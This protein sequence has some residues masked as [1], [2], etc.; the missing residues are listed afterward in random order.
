MEMCSSLPGGIPHPELTLKQSIGEVD[1]EEAEERIWFFF[2]ARDYQSSH[3]SLLS[4]GSNEK[5]DV[6]QQAH[7]L[8]LKLWW[9][10]L[11]RATFSPWGLHCVV[12]EGQAGTLSSPYFLVQTGLYVQ[13]L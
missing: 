10:S 3:Y 12:R 11:F 6:H 13:S 8:P 1:G 9:I 7:L 4:V 2:F 5:R